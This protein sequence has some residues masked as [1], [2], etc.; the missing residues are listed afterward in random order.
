[1]RAEIEQRSDAVLDPLTGL[2]NRKALAVRF[3]EIAQQAALTGAPIC[4]IAVRP[5]P[6]QARQRRARPHRGDA[7]L[8]DAAYVLRK[9]LR[10]FELVYRLGGEEFL[11][12]LPG[13]DV[14]EGRTIAERVRAASRTRDPP[15]SPS[16]RRSASP[17]RGGD[18]ASTAVPRADAALYEAKRAGRNRVVVAGY[19]EPLRSPRSAGRP[20]R[21]RS[22][23]RRAARAAAR[24]RRAAPGPA[25]DD[26]RFRYSP[27]S[28][29]SPAAIACPARS[30]PPTLMSRSAH[31]LSAAR[32]PGR[33]R[34]RS[35]CARWTPRRACGSRRSSRPPARSAGSRASPPIAGRRPCVSQ[36][37]I[38]RT[39]GGRT[40]RCRPAAPVVDERVDLLVGR[41]P[42]ELAVG[43]VDVAVQ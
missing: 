23:A 33:T 1:M 10:S 19:D 37:A 2:L 34:A 31:A 6:L 29:T 30:G 32:P 7:V 5:G 13:V 15:A 16:P 11:I 28:S 20:R 42:V 22:G 4:L 25:A 3:D 41:G 26:D 38:T 36:T 35:A 43:V 8:K 18:V 24:R 40:G 14:E 9:S 27:I 12:V 39:S 21:C 17:Q